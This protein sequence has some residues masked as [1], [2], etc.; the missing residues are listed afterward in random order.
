MTLLRT[1]YKYFRFWGGHY[2]CIVCGRYI[3]NYFSFSDDLQYNAKSNGF[4]Y[5]F[6]RIETLNFENYNCPFCMSSDRER[7]YMIFLERYLKEIAHKCSILDFAP[8]LVFSN[9]LRVTPKIKYTSADLFRKDVDIQLDICDMKVLMDAKFD[10]II[11]SHVLEHVPDPDKAMREILRI[12]APNGKAIIMVPLFWDV[13]STSEDSR[14][15][16][17]KLRLQ[18][19]GQEDHVRLFSREDFLNRLDLAGFKVEQLR[20]SDFDPQKIKENAIS[21]NS[22]LY[23]CSRKITTSILS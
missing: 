10:F 9:K 14:H 2:K 12:I 13:H 15:T 3:R 4:I 20:S 11:C 22:I 6:R 19:Y 1:L 18:H 23:V 21:D 7:L 16:T 8:S 5:D 17:D